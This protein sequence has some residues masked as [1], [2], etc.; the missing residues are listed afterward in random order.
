M[1]RTDDETE[2]RR[3]SPR[4]K[5]ANC[6]CLSFLVCLQAEE[7]NT[8]VGNAFRMAY[9]AQLQRQ[10]ILQDVISPRSTPSYRK[11]KQENRSSWV[12]L[13]HSLSHFFFNALVK[14]T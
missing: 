6:Q 8:I 14:H 10:P 5:P 1:R 12:R 2:I 7:L 13:S 9:V 3:A 4:M 11:D